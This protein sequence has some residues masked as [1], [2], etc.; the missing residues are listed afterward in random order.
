MSIQ[1]CN[2]CNRKIDTDFDAEHFDCSGE[3]EC[4]EEEYNQ[5]NN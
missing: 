2:Y 3:Y 4:I 5:N 1:Y